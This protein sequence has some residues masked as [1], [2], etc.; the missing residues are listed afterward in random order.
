M[1]ERDMTV[2]RLRSSQK[3]EE[4][5]SGKCTHVIVT[6]QGGVGSTSFMRVLRIVDTK[7]LYN[8][9]TQVARYLGVRASD[10]QAFRKLQYTPKPYNSSAPVQVK[11]LF[12]SLHRQIE[13]R[14]ESWSKSRNGGDEKLWK[15]T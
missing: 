6:S 2:S 11:S 15:P 7:T 3:S 12:D 13:E 8:N 5:Y 10:L 9:A 4:I 14:L 1:T